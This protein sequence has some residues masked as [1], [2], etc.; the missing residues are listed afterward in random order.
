MGFRS[1]VVGFLRFWGAPIFRPEVPNPLK[2]GHFGTSG[3]KSRGAPKTPK[4][5]HDSDLTPHLPPSDY[6]GCYER[7]RNAAYR[8][9]SKLSRG[10]VL[11]RD[12]KMS[13]LAHA[14]ATL[15]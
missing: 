2:I 13:L 10:N 3:L 8:I 15:K 5:N 11:S 9:L 6:F 7:F 12:I 14:R 4:S 1:V